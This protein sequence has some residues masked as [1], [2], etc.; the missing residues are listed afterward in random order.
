MIAY[1]YIQRNLRSL[2][3]R[4]QKAKT[5]RDANYH[6]KL[7]ILELCG[8]LEIA[9]DEA[10]LKTASRLLK[11]EDAKKYVQDKVKKNYGFEYDRHLKSLIVSLVGVSG[12]ERVERLI[13]VGILLNFKSELDALKIRRNSL[14]HTY[15]RGATQFYDAPSITIARLAKV[16]AGIRAYDTNLRKLYP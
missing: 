4:Y 9:I 2:D 15:T 16:E 14:A 11:S 12:F 10:I 3:F 1:C 5:T 6:S 13:D 7:A 8:W